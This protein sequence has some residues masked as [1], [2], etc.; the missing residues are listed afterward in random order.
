M[1]LTRKSFLQAG[2]ATAAT[3]LARPA[4]AKE[5]TTV[6]VATEG[7]FPPFN[8][9]APDGTLIGFEPDMCAELAKR[10]KIAFP[11]LAQAW[12]GII[13]GLNDGKYDA[14][15]DGMSIT[16]KREEVIAFSRP[17][18]NSGSGFTVLKDGPLASMAGTGQRVSLDDEAATKDVIATL[19]KALQGKTV[20]VQVAT[21]QFDLL[22][23]YF[24]DVVTVRTYAAGPD[25][26]L[27]LKNGRADA[28][29]SST[30]NAAPF[31]K[32]SRGDLV[33]AGTAFIGGVL[34][35]GSAF[36]LRKS[37]A[38]LKAIID[39]GLASMIADGSL[40]ALSM[41]WFEFDVTPK[42]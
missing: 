42:A 31:I 19:S 3:V 22:T 16:A 29:L 6:R 4:L 36:G 39:A 5:W 17:Y 30:T 2:L 37:D 26:Y 28:V 12:D 14:I 21:I 11:M 32:R 24:K 23:K 40:K 33:L 35:Q 41:K 25:T 9:T 7:A 15:C 13:P 27:D 18:T 34:G 38:D 10:Q 20:A 8:S 1:L